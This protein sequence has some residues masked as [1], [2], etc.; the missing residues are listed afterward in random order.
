VKRARRTNIVILN[1]EHFAP[2]D[3]SFAL[4]VARALRP[5]GYSILA[6]EAFTSSADLAQRERRARSLRERGYPRL[7]SGFYTK[8]P[9]FADFVR[10]SLALGYRPVNYEYVAPNG[11]PAPADQD[12]AREQGEAD[13]LM[14]A[15]FSKDPTAKVLIYV[16]YAHA[17]EGPLYGGEW[18]TARLKHLTGID[19]LTIDQTTLSPT[20]NEASLYAALEKRLDGRSVVPILAGKPLKFGDLGA[21]VDLQVAH[22]PTRLVR[23]RPDWLYKSGRS[24]VEV[25]PKL[26]PR[27]GRV[28]VQAFKAD[29]PADA[30]PL[31]QVLVTAGQAPPPLLAPPGPVRF[32]VRSGYRPGDCEVDH[33]RESRWGLPRLRA[34]D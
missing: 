15:I 29:E 27:R 8:D 6:A 17:A 31:D 1:E 33:K 14:R 5:L 26:R 20:G 12:A 3:R 21:A 34:A 13:N 2:R 19:P 10:H 7:E 28:L 23:G 30:V 25:P 22:A 32:A 16:G 9:V 11:A 4:Q 18:M 24:V